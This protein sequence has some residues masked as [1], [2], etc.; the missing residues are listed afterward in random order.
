MNI[1]KFLWQAVMQAKH[2]LMKSFRKAAVRATLA[3]MMTVGVLAPSISV[4][5]QTPA[6]PHATISQ[7]I[8]APEAG[9]QTSVELQFTRVENVEALA[10]QY[11]FLSKLPAE[12]KEYDKQQGE[13]VVNPSYV[14]IAKY[15]DKANGREL[16][17]VH[18]NTPVLCSYEGCPL[19]VFLKD[20]AKDFREVLGVNAADPMNFVVAKD[21][22][23]MVFGGAYGVGDGTTFTYNAKTDMFEDPVDAA[24]VVQQKTPAPEQAPIQKPA[25]AP[26]K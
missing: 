10:K 1:I 25:P 18:V 5:A 19:S 3:V 23:S 9:K 8:P 2:D 13:E 4:M 15:T 21:Q 24:P 14:R 22:M 17:F 20:G 12:L 16:V 6:N 26:K 7:T 11:P